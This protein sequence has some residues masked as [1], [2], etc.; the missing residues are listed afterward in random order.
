MDIAAKMA[1]ENFSYK[2][3]SL[4]CIAIRNDGVLVKSINGTVPRTLKTLKKTALP[5]AHAE[6]RVLK[7]AGKG[8]ILYVARV[9]RNGDWALS[10][11]CATCRAMIKNRNVKI[12]YYTIGP[13]EWGVW[14]P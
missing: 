2:D 1:L 10:R 11:P 8:A 14:I 13:S 12:V 3:Y 6:V 4:A 7:K 5:S 9:W